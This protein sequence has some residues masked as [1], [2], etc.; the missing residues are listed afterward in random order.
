METVPAFILG[1]V[2]DGLDDELLG[3]LRS[4][5]RMVGTVTEL[6]LDAVAEAGR[7]DVADRLRDYWVR[8]GR[9]WDL[10]ESGGRPGAYVTYRRVLTRARMQDGRQGKVQL[11]GHLAALEQVPGFGELAAELVGVGPDWASLPARGQAFGL[12]AERVDDKNVL[13][14]V[15]VGGVCSWPVCLGAAPSRG[16]VF[17]HLC[18]HIRNSDRRNRRLFEVTV[19]AEELWPAPDR[20]VDALR[21]RAMAAHG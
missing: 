20:V 3:V 4:C 2:L 12:S 8:C 19:E 21:R 1:P 5:G 18:L 6:D 15:R 9:F 13:V 17:R 10:W 11:D 16:E 7:P 14:R